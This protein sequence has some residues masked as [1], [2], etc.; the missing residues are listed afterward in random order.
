MFLG[1]KLTVRCVLYTEST[2]CRMYASGNQ[3]NCQV[4]ALWSETNSCLNV[5]DRQTNTSRSEVDL[6]MN[7]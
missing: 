1:V 2:G 4:T 5:S 6:C 7:V 3:A